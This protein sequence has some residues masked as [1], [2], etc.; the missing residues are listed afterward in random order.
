MWSFK[1]WRDQRI[2]ERAE[3]SDAEWED[4]YSYLP[5]LAALSADE[6]HRL[7]DLAV[8]FLHQK[9]I[10]GAGGVELDQVMR[11]II[12]LQACLPI[13]NLG[14]D[15]YDG[16]TSVIVYPDEF[17]PEREYTDEAGV[18]HRTR[19]ALSGEAWLRGPVILAWSE[20]EQAGALDGYNVVVHEFAHKLDMLDGS[21]NGLPPLH[22]EMKV[23]EW[24]SAF[25][26]AFGH[27]RR[28]VGHGRHS[29][30]DPYGADSPAEFFAVL[31][32]CFFETPSVIQHEYPQV[33]E[34]MKL[35]YKQDPAGWR[36]PVNVRMNARN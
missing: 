7:E 26:H 31:S 33:Y 34:Q 4:A 9:S 6:Q 23:E 1:R 29:F 13:L 30:I 36:V 17:V 2:V 12:A 8:L 35:F 16:W 15:W 21:V 24:A 25:T 27:F 22:A 19:H 18:V 14:L 20:V 28:T 11:L 32:E 10:E 5:L 3:I